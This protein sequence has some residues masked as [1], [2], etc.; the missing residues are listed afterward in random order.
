MVERVACNL[1]NLLGVLAE[2][3]FPHEH[4]H[5]AERSPIAHSFSQ[6]VRLRAF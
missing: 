6:V 3:E 2:G 1:F 5:P 4:L